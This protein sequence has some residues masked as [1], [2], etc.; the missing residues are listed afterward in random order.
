MKCKKET[1][2]LGVSTEILLQKILIEEFLE[3]VFVLIADRNIFLTK[4]DPASFYCIDLFKID[5]KRTVYPH[6]FTFRKLR[7]KKFERGQRQNGFD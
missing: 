2:K 5:N 4:Y 1:P 3:F 7:F 6:K